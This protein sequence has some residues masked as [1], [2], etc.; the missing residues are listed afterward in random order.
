MRIQP[1][2]RHLV[3]YKKPKEKKEVKFVLPDD[4]K[5]KLEKHCV[6]TVLDVAKDSKLRKIKLGS[7]V[8]VES[9]MLFEVAGSTLILENYVY[10]VVVNPDEL[11]EQPDEQEEEMFRPEEFAT[12][13]I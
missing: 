10:G 9:S 12:I 2:N 8:I 1:L 7:E 4:Y 6:V 5:P 3:V 11:T 13:E